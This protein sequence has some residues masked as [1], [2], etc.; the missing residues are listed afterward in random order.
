MMTLGFFPKPP[1]P[2]PIIFNILFLVC[3][4]YFLI[5]IYIEMLKL[6]K[7]YTCA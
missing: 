3:W 4:V 6:K 7:I 1:P 5:K 2:P